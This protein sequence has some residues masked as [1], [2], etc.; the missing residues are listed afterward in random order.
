MN[1]SPLSAALSDMSEG[2]LL[3]LYL[4]YALRGESEC[5]LAQ[6][7]RRELIEA[8]AFTQADLDDEEMRAGNQQDYERGLANRRNS[9]EEFGYEMR[10]S[11][12]HAFGGM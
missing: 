4:R 11:R 5:G 7:V 3:A 12:N 6:A 2:D 8:H 10:N 1:T 9:R